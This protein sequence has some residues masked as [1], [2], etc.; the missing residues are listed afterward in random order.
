MPSWLCISRVSEPCRSSWPVRRSCCQSS[1]GSTSRFV[2]ASSRL[3]DAHA[4]R[5]IACCFR[6]PS[7]PNSQKRIALDRP[8][9]LTLYVILVTAFS[10]LCETRTIRAV[11]VQ[12][13][14][15]VTLNIERQT[16]GCCRIVD[17]RN[18]ARRLAAGA[19]IHRWPRGGAG[20]ARCQQR[21]VRRPA[22]AHASH[23]SASRRHQAH[24]ATAAIGLRNAM[25]GVRRH[26]QRD[27]PDTTVRS[28]AIS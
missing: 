23:A 18:S 8:L 12:V 11:D 10:R 21:A 6:S 15:R 5:S 1:I 2:L 4:R 19:Y 25:C 13:V 26:W 3:R 14:A 24:S 17:G 27:R 16:A 9:P 28:P 7:H 22:L 20:T